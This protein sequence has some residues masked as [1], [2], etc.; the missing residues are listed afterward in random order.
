[1]K[2]DYLVRRVGI[3]GVGVALAISF[4]AGQAQ[5]ATAAQTYAAREAGLT[6]LSSQQNAD[7][8]WGVGG[9]SIRDTAVS[10]LAYTSEYAPNTLLTGS[11][12]APYQQAFSLTAG[13]Q[14]TVVRGTN[15]LLSQA[16]LLQQVPDNV[17]NNI[18]IAI[19]GPGVTWGPSPTD[20]SLAY[21]ALSRVALN[22][23]YSGQDNAF[24]INGPVQNGA[25]AGMSMRTISQGVVNVLASEFSTYPANAGW[26]ANSGPSI[27]AADTTSA[28]FALTLADNLYASTTP[29]FVRAALPYYINDF[30]L[31]S[32]Q[33]TFEG[34]QGAPGVFESS[35]VGLVASNFLGNVLNNDPKFLAGLNYIG[36]NWR[37]AADNHLNRDEYFNINDPT[38]VMWIDALF[39]SYGT[40]FG[41]PFVSDLGTVAFS[42]GIKTDQGGDLLQHAKLQ[43]YVTQFITDCGASSGSLPSG[44]CNWSQD[45]Q[46]WLVTHQNADGSFNAALELDRVGS[47]AA[48]LQAINGYNLA[49]VPEPSEWVLMIAGLGTIGASLRRRRALSRA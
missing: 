2:L 11:I 32:G 22:N 37:G 47:T 26:G 43:P 38:A 33:Y 14:A 27:T 6:F 4:A 20:T 46:E 5:G 17:Q 13:Q 9:K 28:I 19:Q 35:V 39:S 3:T 29:Q 45:Y 36:N 48:Y 1:M 12:T 31:G 44:G 30:Y 21:Q 8:S 23:L 10:L 7:G 24:G 34:L 25:L 15:Y 16:R 42:N 40:A 41:G 18:K 49:G